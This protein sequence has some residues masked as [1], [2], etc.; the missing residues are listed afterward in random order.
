[1]ASPEETERNLFAASIEL[2]HDCP[3]SNLSRKFPNLRIF[4]WCVNRRDVFQVTGPDAQLEGFRQ[5]VV[6]GFGGRQVYS[7][8]EGMILVTEECSCVPPGRMRITELISS[9]G[10][11]DIP[12]IVY[13]DGWESWRVI[14][15]TDRSMRDMFAAIRKVAELRLVSMRPIENLE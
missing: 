3:V 8:T 7:T 10:V 4:H 12:P 14:A 6:S 15:W 11:W 2:R 9:V 13:R 5:V 1:M